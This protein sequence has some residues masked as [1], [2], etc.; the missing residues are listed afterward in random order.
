MARRGWGRSLFLAALAAAGS[1]AAQLG[2]GYGLSIIV[3]APDQAGSADAAWAAGLAWTVWTAATSVVVGAVIG[4]RVAGNV[5]SGR[6]VRSLARLTTGVAAALGALTAIPLVAVPTQDVRIVDTFAPNLLAGIYAAAGV[7]IG[8]I[9]ALPAMASRAVAA[10]VFATTGFLWLLAIVAVSAGG[11]SAEVTQLGIWKFTNQGPVWQGYYVPGAL[12]LLGG[13]LM[14][15]G[16][17]AFPAAGRGEGRF[18]VAMSGIAGPILVAVAYTLAAPRPGHATVE[19]LSA[20]HAS[21]YMIVAG[22]AG[23]VL[24]GAVGAAPARRTRKPTAVTSPGPPPAPA[25]TARVPKPPPAVPVPSTLPTP[26]A[27]RRSGPLPAASAS[28]VTAKASVPPELR[29]D[30]EEWR[31]A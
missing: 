23:S 25:A 8:L 15:G 5:H 12:L 1:A 9:V 17:A 21:P 26:D 20:F 2:L 22:L 18:G 4:D 7:V 29:I 19:Q 24:V 6:V 16:L 14:L 13:A 3:W 31:P 28:A 11:A 27:G 30:P 10:N